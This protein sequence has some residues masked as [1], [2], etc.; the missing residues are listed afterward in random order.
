V[1]TPWSPFLGVAL[2]SIAGLAF[3]FTSARYLV[4]KA[5]RN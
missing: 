4:F 2:G 5:H 3:N 1:K